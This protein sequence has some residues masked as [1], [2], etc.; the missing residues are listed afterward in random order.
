MS[1]CVLSESGKDI[2]RRIKEKEKVLGMKFLD[3]NKDSKGVLSV[4]ID[5]WPE[6]VY[7]V[8]KILYMT[9][10]EKTFNVKRVK[11]I[12]IIIDYHKNIVID[13]KREN[14]SIEW[15]VNKI[16]SYSRNN[17]DSFLTENRNNY[18]EETSSSVSNN[19]N[20]EI[21]KKDFVILSMKE[22][23]L[24]KMSAN[25]VANYFGIDY[26]DLMFNVR[27]RRNRLLTKLNLN[28]E[29]VFNTLREIIMNEN[30][31]P[32]KML[33]IDQLVYDE[34]GNCIID[35][36]AF[37]DV[38]SHAG[39]T[40]YT[41]HLSDVDKGVILYLQSLK[42]SFE[43][44]ENRSAVEAVSKLSEM[45]VKKVSRDES[46][47]IKNI[48]D[49]KFDK[50]I[51]DC[52]NS[53]DE[54]DKILKEAESDDSEKKFFTVNKSPEDRIKSE[55][56]QFTLSSKSYLNKIPARYDTDSATTYE[57]LVSMIEIRRIHLLN[58]LGLSDSTILDE[59]ESIARKG[60]SLSSITNRFLMD[61]I[62]DDSLNCSIYH[63][64]NIYDLMSSIGFEAHMSCLSDTAMGTLLYLESLTFSYNRL[65]LYDARDY[66]VELC[67][68][69]VKTF[70]DNFGKN[71]TTHD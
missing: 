32:V 36:S 61:L 64:P 1:K 50:I 59:I 7:E 5:K 57:D 63:N 6:N 37:N 44:N 65:F 42:Y 9:A 16:N 14:I 45:Y 54:L 33:L 46:L 55:I 71:K 47:D 30:D 20:C 10:M 15:L 25:K 17:L 8:A 70:N 66:V 43:C 11:I 40:N 69:I 38:I 2:N 27:L 68:E 35:L 48:S 53:G 41:S 3:Y 21:S 62:Y 4:L 28:D 39:F 60:G 56:G 67:R 12:N 31:C 22:S 52:E 29:N 51:K 49:G 23:Y 13:V 58:I 24:C 19:S 26:H 18:V 34:V